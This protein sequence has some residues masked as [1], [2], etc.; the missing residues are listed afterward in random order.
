MPIRIHIFVSEIVASLFTHLLQM[1]LGERVV[2]KIERAGLCD[3]F[4]ELHRAF[5]H[6]DRSRHLPAPIVLVEGHQL[7]D[8]YDWSPAGQAVI[9]Y[10]C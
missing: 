3:L 2:P 6:L 10:I 1:M 9:A 8:R 5:D 7:P 4:R